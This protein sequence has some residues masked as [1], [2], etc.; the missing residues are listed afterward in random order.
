MK[1]MFG[2]LR[3][4]RGNWPLLLA[5]SMFASLCVGA[6]TDSARDADQA[7]SGYLDNHNMDPAIVQGPTFGRGFPPSRERFPQV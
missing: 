7:Q 6:P 4:R 1:K 2:S 3:T 5:L